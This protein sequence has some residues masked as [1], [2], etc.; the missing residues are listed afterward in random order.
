[1]GDIHS[2]G[3]IDPTA[4][5]YDPHLSIFLQPERIRVGAHSR[6]DGLVRIEGGLGVEI[7]NYC[8]ISTG[9]KIIGGGYFRIGSHS[10][11]SD[12]VI[13]ATGQPDLTFRHICAADPIEHRHALRLAV[14]IG[15]HVVVFA[16]ARIKPNVMIGDCAAVGMG[17]VVTKDVPAYAIVVGNP[18]RVVGRRVPVGDGLMRL[19]WLPTLRDLAAQR[20][21]ERVRQHYGDA[22]PEQ[23][24]VD[25]V[26]TINELTRGMMG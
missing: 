18:A 25:L 14:E 11:L 1:M 16:G 24:A 10:G 7:G 20:D 23:V 26:D 15:K 4:I 3:Q 22:M 19:E 13:V 12:D 21:I 17:A 5:L 2:F 9:C 6:I 8:H